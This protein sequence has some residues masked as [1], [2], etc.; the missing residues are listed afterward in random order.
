MKNFFN[1]IWD[2][3]MCFL[4]SNCPYSLN[5]LISILTFFLIVYISVFTSKSYLELLA[6]LV[7]V[8]GVKAYDKM[9]YLKYAE[10]EPEQNNVE[11]KQNSIGFLKDEDED[12]KG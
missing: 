10:P 11:I 3:I 1:K 9:T 6:F 7:A 8:L 2:T 4:S 12:E 5:R